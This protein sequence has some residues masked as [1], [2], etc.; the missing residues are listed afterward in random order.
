MLNE[1]DHVRLQVINPGSQTR[2]SW[3]MI[4]SIDDELGQNL[5][6]AFSRDWGYLTACPTNTGTGLRVSVMLH[7]PALAATKEGNKLITSISNMGYAVRGMYGEGSRAT[8]AFY[9]ISN[10]ATLG[11]SE[12][13]I[14]DRIHSV[15]QQIVD[16]ERE[17]RWLLMRRSGIKLEDKIF[18]AYGTLANA[19][20]ISSIEALQLL[21]WVSLGISIDMLPELSRTD[22]ARLLVLTRPAHLQKYEGKKLDAAARDISRAAVVRAALAS[23]R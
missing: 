11:Q 23:R 9:Q 16:R 3:E 20:S 10:E 18:R 5:D 21:S 19:R 12:K 17:E 13:E 1:E 8:G 2:E 4:N 15:A 6:Y 7:I 14:V 22:V